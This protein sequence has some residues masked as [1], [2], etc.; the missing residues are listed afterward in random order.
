M[1]NKATNV[2]LLTIAQG[3]NYVL[4]FLFTPYLSRSLEKNIY[5]SYSQVLM[6]AELVSLLFS[7]AILQ[8]AMMLFSNLEK[9]FEDS[10]KTIIVFVLGGGFLGAIFCFIFSYF[11]PTLF[12]NELL[13]NWLKIFSIS[14]IGTKLNTV[15]NQALIKVN[16]ASFL[17]RLVISSNFIKLCLALVAIHVFHSVVLL[18][19][20][21]AL[22]PIISCLIQ[23]FLLFK[24][25][26]LDGRFDKEI[27]REI[28]T[29]G[30]PLYV[31]DILGHSY[32]YI[33]G[34]II[35]THWGETSYADYRIGSVELPLIGTIYATISTIFM[36]DMSAQ[37]QNK[38]YLT[39]A[40][41]KRKIISTTAVVLFPVAI[42][43]IFFSK[44]FI[45][46]V[47]SGKYTESY[48]IFIVFSM[49]LLIRFQD[50]T[51]ILILLRKSKYVLLSFVVFVIS[52]IVL[53]LTLSIWLGIV[54]CAIATIGSVYI[55]AFM[56]L[57]IT[58]KQLKVRY[59]DY[60]D[61]IKL[62]KILF[63]SVVVIGLVKLAFTYTSINFIFTFIIGG[64]LTLPFLF[65]FFIKNK[66]IDITLYKNIFDKIPIFGS[67]LYK[68][69]L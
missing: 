30:I 50:Y 44:E 37:I 5:G 29:I 12:D 61:F 58:I 23:L 19:I 69:L 3:V 28:W 62:F 24:L 31:V 47:Y 33:A 51:D 13:G 34:F 46:I 64:I 17:M 25:K 21:Y 1:S 16:R 10:L 49:A 67:R 27:L 20:V 41:T 48:K 57:H 15:L 9:K 2:L 4:L 53:N 42:F 68:I 52:N 36:A 22:E 38:N 60:I 45:T 14:I 59:Q 32:T 55:L 43:F 8:I 54:G 35:S 39:V 63:I 56:Q 66:Y 7:L 26:Y 11:A 40:A 6:I 18:L 65:F